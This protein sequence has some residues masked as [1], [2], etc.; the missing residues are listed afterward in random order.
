MRYQDKINQILFEVLDE[1]NLELP[2]NRQLAKSLET[3]LFGKS[4]LLDSL[5]LVNF[6]VAAE[7]KIEETLG[8]TVTLADERAMSHKNNPFKTVGSLVDYIA[9]LLEEKIYE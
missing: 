6:I 9:M 4:G 5:G 3:V 8:E 1:I 7:E 2:S